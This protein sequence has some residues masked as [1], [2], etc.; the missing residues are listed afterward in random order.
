MKLCPT[1]AICVTVLPGASVS[2]TSNAPRV[3]IFTICQ[4][5]EEESA[6]NSDADVKNVWKGYGP[7]WQSTAAISAILMAAQEAKYND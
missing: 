1:S 2:T 3:E 6:I 4:E 7:Q 5:A